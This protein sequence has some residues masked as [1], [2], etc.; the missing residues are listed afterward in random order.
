[1]RVSIRA[2]GIK[3][4]SSPYAVPP[5]ISIMNEQDS[6]RLRRL[7]RKIDWLTRLTY[8]QIAML[9]VFGISYMFQVARMVVLFLIVAVPLLIVFRSSLPRWARGIGRLLA[10]FARKTTSP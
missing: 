8:V 4:L 10:T 6:E 7:E 9:T 5:T 1:M 3:G 2:I